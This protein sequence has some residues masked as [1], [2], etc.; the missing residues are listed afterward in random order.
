MK[1]YIY[2]IIIV[3]HNHDYNGLISTDGGNKSIKINVTAYK[4]AD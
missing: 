1:V 3:G 2:N 4:V